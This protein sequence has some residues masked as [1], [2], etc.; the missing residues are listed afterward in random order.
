MAKQSAISKLAKRHGAK[1]ETIAS[2][3]FGAAP[4]TFE[5]HRD[6]WVGFMQNIASYNKRLLGA[7][8]K[9]DDDMQVRTRVTKAIEKV[10]QSGGNLTADEMAVCKWNDGKLCFVIKLARANVRL[11]I[12]GETHLYIDG[13]DTVEEG[14]ERSI[15][16]IEG[17]AE[18][19]DDGDMDAEIKKWLADKK[20]IADAAEKRLI[21]D[22]K[23]AIKQGISSVKEYRALRRDTLAAEKRNMSVVEY[24]A[25]REKGYL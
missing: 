23:A 6:S 25:K 14:L 11:L 17:I 19:I 1:I 16:L 13:E 22:E 18:I 20:K 3:A 10:K 2:K 5:E 7:L 12:D 8:R 15:K 24:R 4:K 21:A 9:V